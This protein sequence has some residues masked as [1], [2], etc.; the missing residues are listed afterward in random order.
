LSFVIQKTNLCSYML[1]FASCSRRCDR[2]WITY[3]PFPID[4]ESCY[5]VTVSE[6]AQAPNWIQ[7]WKRGERRI[8]SVVA[9][10]AYWQ[11]QVHSCTHSC[12]HHEISGAVSFTTRQLNTKESRFFSIEW[13]VGR[14][15]L[16]VCTLW[17]WQ[18]SPS[19]A[20]NWTSFPT[21]KPY[22]LLY[23]GYAIQD[24]VLNVILPSKLPP[25]QI[26]YNCRIRNFTIIYNSY[27]NYFIVWKLTQ[28]ILLS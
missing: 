8:V 21:F 26:S 19:P 2:Y 6:I 13:E 22:R 11:V 1:Y 25:L 27:E 12:T 14:F 3:R 5:Q 16:S 24:I 20:G 7:C 17:R 15:T 23:V 4:E 10:T 9:M 18:K 28:N